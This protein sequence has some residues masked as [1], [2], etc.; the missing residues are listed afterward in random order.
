ML[1]GGVASGVKEV[2]I[3]VS[4]N[5]APLAFWRFVTP[6]SPSAS[7]TGL[8]GHTYGF[9]SDAQDFA[10][11]LESKQSIQVDATTYVPYMNQPITTLAAAPVTASPTINLTL[12]GSDPGGP[13]LA[14]FKVYLEIDQSTTMQLVATIPAGTPDGSGNYH[15]A[16]AYPVA[17]RRDDSHLPLLQHRGRCD[18]QRRADSREPRRHGHRDIRLRREARR[19]AGR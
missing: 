16:Y 14:V 6:A 13:G 4:D 18:E 11:N 2:A 19:E 15:A 8:A 12:T 10:G 3:Y 9:Q 7:F 17:L 5:G 1:S